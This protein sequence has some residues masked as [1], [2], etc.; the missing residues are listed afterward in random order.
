MVESF[1]GVVVV[2][3]PVGGFGGCS[4]RLLDLFEDG[5]AFGEGSKMFWPVV[6]GQLVLGSHVEADSN[7][8]VGF[9]GGVGD[10]VFGGEPYLSVSFVYSLVDA[11]SPQRGQLFVSVDIEYADVGSSTD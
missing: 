5:V 2:D 3:R 6:S 4:Q 10:F 11:P 1:P 7:V 9:A 8:A